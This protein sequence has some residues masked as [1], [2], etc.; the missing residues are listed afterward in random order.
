MESYYTMPE[1]IPDDISALE[2]WAG[3]YQRGEVT[4][5]KFKGFRVPLGIYEQ[6]Q[7]DTFMM[8]V[9]IAGGGITPA[10]LRALAGIAR[11]KNVQLHVT[12]RQDIQ[13]QNVSLNDLPGIYR[14]LYD[15]GLTCKGGG[16]N[17]VR[18]I[19]ACPDSGVCSREAFNVLPYASALTNY[20]LPFP[21]SYNLP[22]K[23]KVAFSACS[24]DCALATVNDLGF[25]AKKQNGARGFSVY[26][27]GG[28]GTQA[29]AA[30][31]LHDFVPVEEIGSVSEAVKRL[32]D[33]Y[34][35][36]KHK[37]QARLRF[38]V[39]RLGEEEFRKRYEH[40]L[41]EVKREGAVELHLS[42]LDG[43]KPDGSSVPV[44]IP[45]DG[46]DYEEWRK[47]FALPQSQKRYFMVSVP[48]PLGDIEPETLERFA[49]LCEKLGSSVRT[50]QTQGFLLRWV[51][52]EHLPFVY[53]ELRKLNLADTANS[54]NSLV[55]CK[56]A[57]TCKL[58]FCLSQGVC[59]AIA[60]G[61]D[62]AG[63]H[64]SQFPEVKIRV[65]G[66]PNSCGQHQI[67]SIGIHG[68][69]RRVEGRSAPFYTIML[70]GV[71]HEGKTKLA[72]SMGQVPAKNV[73][74][75]F[76]D[77]LKEYVSQRKAGE[78]F[79]DFAEKKGA[80][81]MRELVERYK[82][83]PSYDVSRDFYRDWDSTEEFSLAGRSAGECGAGMFDMIQSDL[84][85]AKTS[86]EVF[87]QTKD[88]DLLFSAVASLAY[89]LLVIRGIDPKND[90]EALN[91]FEMQFVAQGWVSGRYIPLLHGAWEYAVTRN[92]QTLQ[93]QEA[94]VLA[95]LERLDALYSSLDA[96]LQFQ[97]GKGE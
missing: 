86:Y 42:T 94:M 51:R 19:T 76:R 63:I 38:V 60:E 37:Q 69:S 9:R 40:E 20:F 52:E 48:L 43:E 64:L 30:V 46:N 16:G 72:Q 87:R 22:R 74:A 68:A 33:R 82:P 53:H 32:F 73:P 24:R 49:D 8:R 95:L 59:R 66:C 83:M 47:T 39:A 15:I 57:S 50:T 21:S 71:V 55:C 91:E 89:S 13:M 23:F 44:E 27:A 62:G 92:A 85:S 34:G 78:D 35:D 31:K 77:F 28:L 12:T 58:G 1:S 11:E 80:P 17:T 70:G 93:Q 75:L 10:Q 67:G 65:S 90:V 5:E 2:E 45:S 4:Y 56:G 81:L 25:I 79:A 3:R 84:E 96:S 18:N 41:D 36:R 88:P 6:R 54:I 14:E 26:A 29:R 97:T 7:A 61:L